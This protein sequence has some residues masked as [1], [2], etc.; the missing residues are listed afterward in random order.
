[1]AIELDSTVWAL[2]ENQH[3]VTESRFDLQSDSIDSESAATRQRARAVPFAQVWVVDLVFPP[4]PDVRAATAE[5]A[6]WRERQGFITRLRGTSGLLRVYDSFRRRPAYDLTHDP[7]LANWSGG[8]TWSDG[9]QWSSGPL[10][11][12][13]IV[14][15]T[16]RF[17]ETSI[18]L[19]GLPADTELVLSPA[20]LMEGR[21]NGIPTPY[22]NL[23]ETVLCARSNS[24]GKA[25]VYLQPGLR[26]GFA[27]GDPFYLR[28]ASCVFRLADKAQGRVT[29]SVGNI[30]R[31]GMSLIEHLRDA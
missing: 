6:S 24:A 15:E 14:D 9:S 11:P 10:P 30:G 22:G 8:A 3:R 7:V 21:P 20:D 31:S 2:P 25:R 5:K 4:A 18:V 29:R 16:A 1:M 27:P 28:D 26:Q 19:R 23:Y 12:F 13:L 17:E